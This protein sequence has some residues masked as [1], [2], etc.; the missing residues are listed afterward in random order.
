MNA[1]PS[2]APRRSVFGSQLPPSRWLAEIWQH[3]ELLTFLI[4]RDIKLRYRQTLLGF[5]WAILQPAMTLLL[6]VVLLGPLLKSRAGNESAVPYPLI[7]LVG[8]LA[9]QL[10]A[11]TVS[12]ASV[13]LMNNQAL[14]T[15]VYFPRLLLPLACA[16]VAVVDFAITCVLVVPLMIWFGVMPT[17]SLLALPLGLLL[18][19]VL[20]LGAG[21]L[22]SA[23]VL[24]YRD[25]RIL[26]PFGLQLMFFGSPVMYPTEL[27]ASALSP[28]FRT[29][30]LLNPVV[31]AVELMRWIW[32]GA[33]PTSWL[34]IGGT[35]I[36]GTLVLILSMTYFRSVERDF[37]DRA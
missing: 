10:I 16:G 27:I 5:L 4:W 28:T 37:A 34:A 25:L 23:L 12:Q 22:L 36:G 24:L 3:R 9:W 11:T 2:P 17:V 29:L 1:A 26:V 31:G 21:I 6:F 35:A 19:L 33:P 14:L 18:A 8:L 15:K 20:A 13:S 32:L 7:A 30:Y